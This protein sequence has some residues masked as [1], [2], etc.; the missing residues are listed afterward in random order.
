MSSSD[1]FKERIRELVRIFGVGK[2]S[3]F[4]QLVGVSEANIR[5][6]VGKGV[7]PNGRAIVAIL[8]AFRDV[9]PTWFILGEGDMFLPNNEETTEVNNTVARINKPKEIKGAKE[10][11]YREDVLPL[12]KLTDE[13]FHVIQEKDREIKELKALLDKKR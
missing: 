5:A 12:I 3:I 9:S 8:E 10:N 1:N 6:Y 2:V 7:I 13:M 4:A 11:L